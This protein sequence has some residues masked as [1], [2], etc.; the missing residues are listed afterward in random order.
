M[1]GF[2][3]EVPVNA[4]RHSIVTELERHMRT[5]RRLLSVGIAC[6]TLLGCGDTNLIGVDGTLNF[7]VDAQ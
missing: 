5:E 3:K 2:V 4:G 7:G 6:V 1:V